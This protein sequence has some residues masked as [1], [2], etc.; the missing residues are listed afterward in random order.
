MSTITVKGRNDFDLPDTMKMIID[1]LN[2][3]VTFRFDGVVKSFSVE[4]EEARPLLELA[5]ELYPDEVQR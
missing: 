5:R 2:G 1:P 3:T 4:R